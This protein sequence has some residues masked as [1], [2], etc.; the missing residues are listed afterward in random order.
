MRFVHGQAVR[1]L[2]AA[3]AGRQAELLLSGESTG[4]AHDAIVVCTGP[5]ADVLLTPLGVRL[6]SVQL[7][8][9]TVSAPL[10]D[11]TRM[12]RHAIVD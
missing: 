9:Y 12:P 4:R 7:A 3:T 2:Q 11:E 6:P 8:G 5:L 1:R 10:R